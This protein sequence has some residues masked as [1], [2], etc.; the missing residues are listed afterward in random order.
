MTALQC[1]AWR[2]GRRWHAICADLDVAVDGESLPAI[3]ASLETCVDLYLERVAELPADER[4]R[5]LTRRAPWRVRASLAT[6]TWLRRLG[7]GDH[8]AR[9][10]RLESHVFAP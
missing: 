1:Y 4:R 9:S 3:V 7:A 5:F 2:R 6:S 8:N 10:F